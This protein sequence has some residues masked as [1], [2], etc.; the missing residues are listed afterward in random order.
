M[1]ECGDWPVG[2]GEPSC[3][4]E[5]PSLGLSSLLAGAIF[6]WFP[7]LPGF[8]RLRLSGVA[9]RFLGQGGPPPPP[10]PVEESLVGLFD[11]PLCASVSV[12]AC[13]CM[14]CSRAGAGRLCFSSATCLPPFPGPTSLGP[15]SLSALLSSCLV[16]VCSHSS[17]AEPPA[18]ADPGSLLVFQPRHRAPA[19]GGWP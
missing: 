19:T 11:R 5:G 16:L 18:Q 13:V 17:D 3:Q 8:E 15:G 7:E 10:G 2:S 6:W 14:C 9:A 1:L 4:A 12:R